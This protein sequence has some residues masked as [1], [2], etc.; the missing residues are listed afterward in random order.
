[1]RKIRKKKLGYAFRDELNKVSKTYGHFHG[2]RST[3][4]DWDNCLLPNYQSPDLLA[5]V[6][7]WRLIILA[8][9]FLVT[10][11]GLFLRLFHLQIVTGQENKERAD[12][13]RVQVRVIHAPRGVIYDRNGKILAEN[14]PGFRLET[15]IIDREEALLWEAKGD[16][17]AEELEVDAIRYYPL[18]LVTS[19]IIGYVGQIT[20]EELQDPQYAGY[21]TGDRVGRS[22]IEKYYEKYLKGED[23]AEI[24]EIDASGKKLRVLRQIAPK[25]GRNIY[26]SVN[27]ELQKAAYE[28]LQ[29]GV[30]KA[31]VCC[32]A[33]VAEDPNTGEVLALVSLPSFDANS[34]TDPKRA[35]EITGYFNQKNSPML[36]RV[37]AGMYPPG[38]T[39][40][41]VSALAGLSSGKITASTLIEDT[42]IMYLG[43]FS[44]A[45]WYFTQ[46]GG[47]DGLVDV[48]KALQRS[49]D[50]F[51]YKVGEMVGQEILAETSRKIGLGK[52]LGIDLP[53]EADGLIADSSWKEKN[54]GEQWYPGDDLHMAIG[55]GFLLATPLQVLA[56]TSFVAAEGSLI[57]PHLVIKITTSDGSLVKQFSFEPVV[58]DIFKKEDLELVKKG[59]EAVPKE[60]GTAWPFFTFP[61]ATAGKTGTAEFGDPQGRTHAWYTTYAPVDDP[62]IALTVL[63]EAGGEGSSDAAPVARQIYTHYFN[64]KEEVPALSDSAR[65]FGE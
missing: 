40:K 6:S 26:L 52:K 17:R 22:G 3:D 62:K 25:P 10:F 15:K 56:Q 29:N 7:S 18:A 65:L 59:L 33:V 63:L 12:F 35:D 14:N 39:Y 8:S 27:A 64:I 58:K 38:S 49:N 5:T 32:G 54:I 16:A 55:Q 60:G 11:F 20:A 46:H 51:F 34:F 4:P 13:N 48:V 61:I 36:N 44:F 24:V 37:I 57:I 41:I 28:A 47:K 9:I 1:M 42:G 30:K 19:H 53:G 31:D 50:I 43:R 45:N 21:K 23:G 2:G